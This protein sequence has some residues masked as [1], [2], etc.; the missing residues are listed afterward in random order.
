[1]YM[2][3]VHLIQ[4]KYRVGQEKVALLPFARVLV[5]YSLSGVSILRCVIE[6]LVNSCA[7]RISPPPPPPPPLAVL[8]RMLLALT[9][10]TFSWP[11]LYIINLENY[12]A[13]D[14]LYLEKSFHL[15]D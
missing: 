5:I 3:R 11:T 14:M 13:R 8:D 10:A 9:R 2:V 12:T 4:C 6:Q 1:M 15:T 7:V